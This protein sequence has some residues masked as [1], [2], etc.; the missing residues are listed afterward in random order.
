[1]GKP[2]AVGKMVQWVIELSQFDIEYK[3]R[4]AIKAQALANFVVE[5]TVTDL[6]LK[7]EY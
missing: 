6:N 3:P 2:N 7:A 1:M 5:F 4:I